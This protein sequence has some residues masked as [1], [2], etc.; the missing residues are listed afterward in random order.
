MHLHSLPQLL[1]LLDAARH[2]DLDSVVQPFHGHRPD[3]GIPL[4]PFFAAV[5]AF[6]AAVAAYFAA[7]AAAASSAAVTAFASFASAVA[8]F[9]APHASG[10]RRDE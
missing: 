5:A 9:S 8:S 4:A 6:F 3:A 7:A 1:L 2:D 10:S